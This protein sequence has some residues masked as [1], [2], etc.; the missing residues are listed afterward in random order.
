M[1]SPIETNYLIYRFLLESGYVHA[2]FMF[3]HES[4][5]ISAGIADRSVPVG[6]LLTLLEKGMQLLDIEIHMDANGRLHICEQPFSL[7][8]PHRCSIK[9]L[10]NRDPESNHPDEHG[11][12]PEELL[13]TEDA[14]LMNSLAVS[15][16][17]LE[18]DDQA[19]NEALALLA[20]NTTQYTENSIVDCLIE[21]KE[22]LPAAEDLI[23][24][25]PAML[26]LHPKALNLTVREDQ[27]IRE[28]IKRIY[29]AGLEQVGNEDGNDEVSVTDKGNQQDTKG[30]H[31]DIR[32]VPPQLFES[33]LQT[34]QQ[35]TD[36]N[37]TKEYI[38]LPVKYQDIL[39]NISSQE[40]GMR[41]SLV[42]R[43]ITVA[44]V[45]ILVIE[46]ENSRGRERTRTSRTGRGNKS[47]GIEISF[48]SYSMLVS[49][50]NNALVASD[51]LA[52]AATH[53][54]VDNLLYMVI[55]FSDGMILVC[56]CNSSLNVS[57]IYAAHPFGYFA[58]RKIVFSDCKGYVV[59]IGDTTRPFVMDIGTYT[60]MLLEQHVLGTDIG[61][62][63][64]DLGRA[65]TDVFV[66]ITRNKDFD[67]SSSLTS[68]P[69]CTNDFHINFNEHNALRQLC[70]DVCWVTDRSFSVLG[71]GYIIILS[72]YSEDKIL[73]L[74]GVYQCSIQKANR[75][76]WINDSKMLA[77][78]GSNCIAYYSV[79][80]TKATE[81]SAPNGLE[82]IQLRML[83]DTMQFSEECFSNVF[84]YQ[85]HIVVMATNGQIYGINKTS[86]TS[87][88]W[89]VKLSGR[90]T[91]VHLA[92]IGDWFFVGTDTGNLFIISDSG[93]VLGELS[94]FDGES[95]DVITGLTSPLLYGSA[96]TVCLLS[97]IY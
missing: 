58:V 61:S 68:W 8:Q 88:A 27:Y 48:I 6:A 20:N 92:S 46:I 40:T 42:E 11:Q 94:I 38:Y 77:V 44:D 2:A 70:A 52:T 69:L 31:E 53:A 37:V 43:C 64:G 90:P 30:V 45:G 81:H 95:C 59:V 21:K 19:T 63:A 79:N 10:R 9:T 71:D 15:K 66:H 17:S 74:N 4:G 50:P 32:L 39:D 1:L 87:L 3:G 47:S 33:M 28:I 86:P 91:Y 97:D 76:I 82:R 24:M 60:S 16:K 65:Y 56:T 57:A 89:D 22:V 29:A 34:V 54:I 26:D 14:E 78:I 7:F 41:G 62:H 72:F 85:K 67:A 93:H 55:G 83:S 51:M 23:N 13:P 73:R 84:D 35:P 49:P 36:V 96:N 80:V 75:I 18:K 12:Q 25:S 5:I